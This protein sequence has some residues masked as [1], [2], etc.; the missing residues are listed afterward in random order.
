MKPFQPP[1]ADTAPPRFRNDG[2]GGQAAGADTAV[3]ACRSKAPVGRRTPDG[4]AAPAAAPPGRA[5]A[6]GGSSTGSCAGIRWR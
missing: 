6:A 4:A 3:S 2:R 5:P 1:G